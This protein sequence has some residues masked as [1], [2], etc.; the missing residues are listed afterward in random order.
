MVL[1]ALIAPA[2]AAQNAP[3]RTA[4]EQQEISEAARLAVE[5]AVAAM[6]TEHRAHRDEARVT[7][8]DAISYYKRYKNEPGTRWLDL[9]EGL[10]GPWLA[11]LRTVQ[12]NGPVSSV[13][14]Q[15]PGRKGEAAYYRQHLSFTCKART[16]AV[17]TWVAYRADGSVL[18]SENDPAAPFQPVVPGSNAEE[19][20]DW[21]CAGVQ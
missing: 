18:L 15:I 17:R 13:W 10:D 2:A 16:S 14:V 19:V 1:A 6:A 7:V 12:P 21:M 4:E 3:V 20:M 8:W 11:D 5:D 9:F